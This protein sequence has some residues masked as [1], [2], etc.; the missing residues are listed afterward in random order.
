MPDIADIHT[1]LKILNHL[2][3]ENSFANNTLKIHA[4]TIKTS[5]IPHELVSKLRGSSLLL[6]SLLARQKDVSLAFPGGCVLGKRPMDAHLMAL[7]AL[8]A[9]SVM[10]DDLIHLKTSGLKG[11]D[12]TM[13]EASVTATE[14]AITAAATAS[15]TTVIRLAASE[16]HVQD[17]CH[18]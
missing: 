3:V 7:E 16:P 17:L 12:F 10:Q 18:F 8:G 13:T 5:A 2:G 4:E 9:Q 6:G 11:V 15:G 1:M 14:N